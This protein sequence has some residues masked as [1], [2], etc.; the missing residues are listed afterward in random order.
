M[1]PPSASVD[2]RDEMAHRLDLREIV[3]AA[4]AASSIDRGGINDAAPLPDA[5][6]EGSCSQPYS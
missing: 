2:P 5:I 3:N 1:R 4:F 6:D